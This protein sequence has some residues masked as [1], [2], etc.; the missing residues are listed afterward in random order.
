MI[1]LAP[2]GV[3]IT[4]RKRAEAE[5]ER[6]AMLVEN[7]R[8]FIG[9][10][11]LD[12]MPLFV[13]RAGLAMIGLSDLEE[14][15]RTPIV[16][17]LFPEDRVRVTEEFFPAL[18]VQ[19]HAEGEV[20][21]RHFTSHAP[22]WMAY[23]VLRLD[24]AEGRPTG[25]ATVSQDVTERRA[26]TEE[27]RTLAA[28]LSDADRRKDE[29]LATLAHELRNPLAP[30]RNMLEVMKRA[31]DDAATLTH[32]R[33]TI[34]RQLRQMVRL[35]DDLLDL[36]RITHD[37]LELRPAAVDLATVIQQAIEASRPLVD[38]AGH[39]LRVA[40]PDEPIRLHA[41]ADRLT[42][43]FANLLNNACKYTPAGGAVAVTARREGPDVVVAVQDDGLGI[44]ADK[45]ESIFD[46]FTQVDRSLE[47]SQ[48]GLGIGLTLA[49]RLAEM[50][51]GSISVRS[52]G[53]GQG[54][55]FIVRLPILEGRAAEPAATAPA[56]PEPSR[57]QALR[58]VVVDD[59]TDAAVSL[60]LLLELAGNRTFTAHDG[61]EALAV[62]ARE[63][64]DVVL[65]DIGLPALGGHEVC[66]RIRA[67]PWGKDVLIL[68][69]TGWGQEDDRRRSREAGF[70][71]HLVKPVDYQALTALLEALVRERD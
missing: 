42:Q 50:H 34:E 27:L 22:R 48:G 56:P 16:E 59:N 41:D 69:L 43:L 47:R 58:I 15:R 23:K 44:P 28:D 7:S 60:A 19:G 63:R 11:D 54:S 30:I 45:L 55:E 64:P 70:D 9:I 21:F 66:R 5:R 57:S 17:F 32:A 10:S 53:E 61:V 62:V 65:L 12:G 1:F 35:V 29:F 40:L 33:D 14:A 39:V 38:A 4:V 36:N 20:R 67:E 25:F 8:D 52:A 68:A 46:M 3:D 2:L 13:N 37:R 6:F 49:K 71:G 26:L 24:D 31:P 18:L 51:G